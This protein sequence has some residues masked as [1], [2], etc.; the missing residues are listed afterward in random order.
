MA[1]DVAVG[2]RS[3]A[4][5]VDATLAYASGPCEP[6]DV[7]LPGHEHLTEFARLTLDGSREAIER[8]LAL[9]RTQLEMDVA[10]VAAFKAGDE[11]FEVVAGD[12]RSFGIE[13]GGALPLADTYCRRVVDGRLPN[14]IPDTAAD[15]GVSSLP[16][17]RSSAIASYVG[18]PV[19]LWDGRLYGVFCCLSHRTHP[20]LNERDVKLMH[21]L[22]RVVAEQIERRELE[23]DKRR[24]QRD[25]IR[26]VLAG[27]GLEI[28]YQPIVALGDGRLA[29]LEALARFRGEPSR[30]PSAWFADASEAGLSVELELAAA[31]AALAGL[32]DLPPVFVALNV[33]PATLRAPRLR[34]LVG[35]VADRIVLELTEHAPV[36]DYA[37]LD[38]ALGT[39]RA[40]GV[41][42]AIDDVGAGFSSLRHILRLAP[43][44]VKLD[45][46]LTCDIGN[47]PARRA[48]ASSLVSFAS[49][50]DA[51]IVAEGIETQEDLDE[52][53]RLG[54]DF[55]Q[56][57]LLSHPARARRVGGEPDP[58]LPAQRQRGRRTARIAAHDAAAYAG[59]RAGSTTAYAV[60][61]EVGM[62]QS[63]EE[64]FSAGASGR[65]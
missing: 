18:V 22:A 37:A 30:P 40:D 65:S 46:S 64:R 25:R 50:I 49:R 32:D 44:F 6:P 26:G 62:S 63:R 39:L 3:H 5:G 9:A 31:E 61:S 20:S 19:R 54:V 2:R 53:R 8:T 41:R 58:A 52:L 17:T 38:R 45:A 29:G 60:A 12:G 23:A 35:A 16:I 1:I 11:V 55:G 34:D 33:S 4:E 42:I 13:E 7:A 24:L 36:E 28:V 27:D 14:A 15:E 51:R 57:F 56:G 43:E 47:D 10:F 59:S 48:L 21:V